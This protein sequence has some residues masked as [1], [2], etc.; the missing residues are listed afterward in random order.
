[1]RKSIGYVLIVLICFFS[2]FTAF[3]AKAED[4]SLQATNETI[5]NI[6][7]D[8]PNEIVESWT[9]IANTRMNLDYVVPIYT[10]TGATI[11]SNSIM[12]TLEFM[13]QY[14]IP[15]VN[16]N[17]EC[18]GMFNVVFYDNHWT[19]NSYREGYD[20][21]TAVESMSQ[22]CVC[23]IEIPQL[24]GDFGFLTISNMEESYRSI[25]KQQA[26][27]SNES[28]STILAQIINMTDS[29]NADSDGGGKTVINN[30]ES[31]FRGGVLIVL[32]AIVLTIYV[33][34]NRKTGT[35]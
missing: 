34:K 16:I 15:V 18:I 4:V 20:F 12:D 22:D 32:G 1:M 21:L 7:A 8:I 25:S 17:G 29:G 2:T 33:V 19:I 23:L 14:N 26:V 3:A 30:H 35:N 10:T 31:Y 27:Y 6:Q 5:A 24:G 13:N 11:S 28:T 9:N